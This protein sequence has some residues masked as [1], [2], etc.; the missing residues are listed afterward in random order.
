MF[1]ATVTTTTYTASMNYSATSM[2][3]SLGMPGSAQEALGAR[4]AGAA[5]LAGMMGQLNDMFMRG[6]SGGLSRLFGGPLSP[7]GAVL[8][9][10]TAM[11]HAAMG[12]FSPFGGVSCE[13]PFGR[14]PVA[15][16][17][18]RAIKKDPHL[19][20]HVEAALGGIIV[21]D[22]RN[23]GK[24]T[25]FRPPAGAI[26]AAMVG[27]KLAAMGGM[28]KALAGLTQPFTAGNPVQSALTR[29]AGNVAGL[30][31]AGGTSGTGSAL[32]T[33]GQQL[34]PEATTM[35]Q[36]MGI[37]LRNASF[38]DIL[39]LLLMKY[40]KKKEEDIMKKVQELDKSLQQS[41][42]G[43]EGA[44]GGGGDSGGLKGA[45]LGQKMDP[46]QMSDTMKQQMLQKLMGDLQKLYEMLSNMIKSMHDMQMTPIRNMRG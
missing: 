10:A 44:K 45:D 1:S 37:D 46:S 4:L 20:A 32:S 5:N 24:L 36:G 7:M 2:F 3:S 40:A 13:R 9:P 35:A 12:G 43:G 38:E 42:K 30:S 31:S 34:G 14:G 25:V 22:R 23:D 39:F 19:K 26:G 41:E 17:M 11:A 16:S 15:R 29:M 8:N 28:A 21:P 33:W 18:E 6:V 27:S